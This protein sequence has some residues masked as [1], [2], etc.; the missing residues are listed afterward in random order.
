M[1]DTEDRL[2]RSEDRG[3][4]GKRLE[5]VEGTRTPTVRG[6][7]L[8]YNQKYGT[9]LIDSQAKAM[10][11]NQE[12]FHASINA[13]NT[14]LAN[15]RSSAEAKYN[16][17]LGGLNTS[18]QKISGLSSKY[19][20]YPDF[21][22]WYAKSATPIGEGWTYQ[23]SAPMEEGQAYQTLAPQSSMGYWDYGPFNEGNPTWVD[24]SAEAEETQKKEFRTQYNE[25]F[26]A[27]NPEYNEW[28][29]S[30]YLPNNTVPVYIRNN[31][32]TYATYRMLPSDAANF[33]SQIGA[34]DKKG[35]PYISAPTE[36]GGYYIE[37]R[38]YGKEITDPLEDY[39]FQMESALIDAY[40][41]QVK[42]DSP[43]L[44]QDIETQRNTLNTD[45]GNATALLS[46]RQREIEAEQQ[47]NT[48]GLNMI[49]MKYQE[50]LGNIKD[51]IGSLIYGNQ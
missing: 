50:K 11:K 15:T 2:Q 48:E 4:L 37:V 28:L 9:T 8:H 1:A 24:L 31:G 43:K 18:Q 41:G 16:E 3:L 47:A 27:T 22:T 26:K 39:K 7:D 12:A 34:E 14:E 19:Q 51:T 42:T 45:Y 5:R 6:E 38:G 13:A 21:D 25:N 46:Q 30:S 20:A 35:S 36:D 17:L 29:A 10:D 40:L 23:E 33:S 49:R 32:Q 44:L